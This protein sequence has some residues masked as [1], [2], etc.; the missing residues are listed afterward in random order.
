MLTLYRFTGA[1]CAAKVLLALS[2]KA[3]AFEDKLL[4]RADLSTDWYR[5]LN[6]NGVVPTIVH[7]GEVIVESSVI[8]TYLEDAFG[9]KQLSPANPIHRAR[10]Y[11]WMKMADDLLNCLGTVSYAIYSRHNYVSKSQYERDKYYSSINDYQLRESRRNAIEFGIHA[12]EI[13]DAVGNL[14]MLQHRMNE[15]ASV[16]VYLAGDYSL[17][18]ISLTP[19]IYRLELLDLLL[20]E[21][22]APSLHR[23]WHDICRRPSFYPSMTAQIP[24]EIVQATRSAARTQAAELDSICQRAVP[25]RKFP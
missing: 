8:L 21:D 6:P 4:T 16:S 13:P 15:A 24:G 3:I 19:F 22:K 18:D 11:R 17:A 7:D 25:N 10:M 5:K 14:M 12:P 9:G 23:W 2:E 20:S 1:T